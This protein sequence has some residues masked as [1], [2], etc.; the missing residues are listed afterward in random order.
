MLRT[1]QKVLPLTLFVPVKADSIV[2]AIPAI[3]LGILKYDIDMIRFQGISII[4][5]M[6][7]S[8]YI[9]NIGV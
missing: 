5:F 4:L 6:L 8:P 1:I 7:H 9:R 2:C 3:S